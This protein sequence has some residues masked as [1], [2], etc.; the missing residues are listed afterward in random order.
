MQFS[1]KE[2]PLLATHIVC[3]FLGVAFSN[4]FHEP[5]LEQIISPHKVLIPVN[6]KQFRLVS[7]KR[8]YSGQKVMLVRY[9]KKKIKIDCLETEAFG[10]IRIRNNSYFV[11]SSKSSSPSY[12][13]LVTG[14]KESSY[15]I[16]YERA[17]LY[18]VCKKMPEV[19]YGGR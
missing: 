8:V 13:K 1:P 12:L 10:K 3:L 19:T 11:E 6:E 17:L 4:I 9:N 16:P 15:L 18:D 14:R 2:W 7:V 5:P